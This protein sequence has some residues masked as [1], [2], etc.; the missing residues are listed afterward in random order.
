MT[1]P[2]AP[3]FLEEGSAHPCKIDGKDLTWTQ[4]TPLSTS[5]L[6]D[7]SSL[8]QQHPDP[9]R[10]RKLTGDTSG[11]TTLLQCRTVA[12]DVYGV[13]MDVHTGSNV[14]TPYYLGYQLYLGRGAVL[15]GNCSALGKGNINHAVEIN[16]G[17]G[18]QLIGTTQQVSSPTRCVVYDPWSKGW[19]YWSWDKVKAFAAALRPWGEGDSRVLGP[20]KMYAMFGPDT[21]PHVH[22]HFNGSRKTTPFPDQQ[23]VQSPVKGK[24]VNVRSGPGTNHAVVTALPSGTKW[25]SFQVTDV[26]QVL[27]GSGRW[28]GN[29]DGD[30]WIHD[31]GLIGRGGGV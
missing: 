11:G 28:W 26:G 29:H 4:C 24:R 2:T 19:A 21:E 25:T 18:Y 23:Q 30:R 15:Q 27:A 17:Q 8:G 14:C 20:G 10:F 31:S 6:I 9:C 3:I 22:L 1:Q 16:Q 7:R 13:P 12:E 5:M